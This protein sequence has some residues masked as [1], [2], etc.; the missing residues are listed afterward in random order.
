VYD[1]WDKIEFDADSRNVEIEVEKASR[2][3]LCQLRAADLLLYS[4]REGRALFCV[5]VAKEE[6][7]SAS[8]GIDLG[9]CWSAKTEKTDD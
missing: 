4:R 8:L 9:N 7:G 5:V 1:E 3:R 2:S 6:G